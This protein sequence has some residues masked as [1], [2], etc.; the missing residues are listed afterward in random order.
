MGKT[1]ITIPPEL[2]DAILASHKAWD[3]LRDAWVAGDD[4]LVRQRREEWL[5]AAERRFALTPPLSN[6]AAAA[7]RY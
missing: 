1:M 4:E 5:R 6:Q 2:A 7:P 3:A